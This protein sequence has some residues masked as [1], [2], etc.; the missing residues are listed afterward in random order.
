MK[1]RTKLYLA[2]IG[3]AVVCSGL[4]I[5]LLYVPTQKLLWNELRH[6]ALSVAATTAAM[7][8]PTLIEQIHVRS[9]EKTP[10]YEELQRVLRKARDANRRNNIDVNFL[11]VLRP[12]PSN[13]K[14]FIYVAD[15]EEDA[16]QVSHVGDTNPYPTNHANAYTAPADFLTDD[17]GTWMTATA[18]VRDPEGKYVATVGADLNAG[19]VQ[20]RLLQLK[21]YG[22]LGLLGAFIPALLGAHI[23]SKRVTASLH[24][25]CDGVEKIGKGELDFHVDLS[26]QDE[27]EELA[28]AIDH[29]A[30]GLKEREHLKINFT[31]YVS[32][33]V[34]DA[35]MKGGAKAKLEGER[36]KIT[37]LFSDIR[38]FTQLAEHLPPQEVVSLLNEYFEV[39]LDVIFS[40]EGTLDKFLGDG[41][42]VEFG[43]PL[44]D[45]DQ[46]KHAVMAAI[47]MQ[48][49][50][51]ILCD[52][53]EKEGKPRIH[54]GIGIHTG[55]A[56]VGNIGSEK[57]LDYTA[58]GDTVNVASRL[59]QATKTLQAP[60]LISETTRDPLKDQFRMTDLGPMTL[61]GRTESIRVYA[62][63]PPG[64]QS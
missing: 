48:K 61:P 15:A 24:T 56:I 37:V 28:K 42:M 27:F 51:E 19:K 30:E 31:R 63:H 2:F 20:E 49:A 44:N 53:W 14:Q 32:K 55:L 22:L 35:I 62:L 18:P 45:A 38:Q 8:D 13:P 58:V 54:M 50:L 21:L 9:D 25:L 23:L 46:E 33:H 40:Y 11:Y 3:T 34:L 57:R 47:E 6:K 60:I 7:L 16:S 39:M 10:A 64:V 26:T 52:R 12:D 5:G 4:G 29:M 1:Y 41:I 59:E 36:K 17:W 43:A